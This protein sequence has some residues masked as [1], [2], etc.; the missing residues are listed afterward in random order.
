MIK[1]DLK[2]PYNTVW[3]YGYVTINRDNRRT[4]LLVG[5]RRRSSTQYA[6]YLL[7]VK[8]G[9]FLTKN[10]TVDHIDGDKANDNIDNLQILS[11]SENTRKSQKKPD[12]KLVCPICKKVF[13]VERYKVSGRKKKEKIK[14][15]E[16]CCSRVC[17]G[18]FSH[19]THLKNKS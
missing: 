2:Y 1:I 8:L 13:V 4:L 19:I 18:K 5:D 12:F 10:E 16:M 7:S 9:R 17:G 14:R 15:G 11:R 6:R 3:K